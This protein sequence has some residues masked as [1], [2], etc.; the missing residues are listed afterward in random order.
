MDAVAPNAAAP[1]RH[2]QAT[3]ATAE[4]RDAQSGCGATARASGFTPRRESL[5]ARTDRPGRSITR[6]HR[7]VSSGGRLLGSTDCESQGN[8]RDGATGGHSSWPDESPT[9]NK[10]TRPRT[11]IYETW[12]G[13]WVP[14]KDCELGSRAVAALM[15]RASRCARRPRYSHRSSTC[16]R[17]I[18]TSLPWTWTPICRCL[19][20]QRW[21]T[22]GRTAYGQRSQGRAEPDAAAGRP[23]VPQC[24]RST[25]RYTGDPARPSVA[26]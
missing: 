19:A 10:Q 11:T 22:R 24:A 14:K 6:T 20:L 18:A 15:R 9:R 5:G 17:A 3:F 7:L 25:R 2:D 8:R 1:R 23:I 21:L 12:P 13:S 16:V 4:R 26:A